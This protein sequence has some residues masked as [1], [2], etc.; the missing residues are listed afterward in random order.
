MV[1]HFRYNIAFFWTRDKENCHLNRIVALQNY[2]EQDCRLHVH[3]I[4]RYRNS[5]HWQSF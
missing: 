5:S 1:L 2:N 3:S 4:I